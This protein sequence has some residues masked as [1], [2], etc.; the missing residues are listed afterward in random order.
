MP[1]SLIHMEKLLKQLLIILARY[2]KL[3]LMHQEGKKHS[4]M[5]SSGAL[6]LEFSNLAR[7]VQYLPD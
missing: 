3:N 5:M 6:D 1:P 2:E 7:T 4:Y